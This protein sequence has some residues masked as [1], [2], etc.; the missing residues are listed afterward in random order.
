[1]PLVNVMVNSRAYT[2]ACDEGEE[3][4]L[5][6]LAGYVDSKVRE[7][8]STV[9]QVGDQKLV[10][11]AAVLITDELLEARSRLDAH[12]KRAG[13]LSQ[14]QAALDARSEESEQTAAAALEDAALRL[15]Q[16]VAKLKAA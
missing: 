3:A 6:E 14:A 5:K 12:A 2:I 11:M 16:M 1:M 13:E 10:L 7:L 4:H 8:S 15:E 9:G